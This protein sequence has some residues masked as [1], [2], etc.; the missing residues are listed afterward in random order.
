M[1]KP[2]FVSEAADW[3]NYLGWRQIFGYIFTAAGIALTIYAVKVDPKNQLLI[4][5]F[6]AFAQVMAAS[7]FSRQGKADPTHAKRSVQR[8][9]GLGLRV[10]MVEASVQDSFENSYT[11]TQR[12]EHMGQV[13]VHLGGIGEDVR[14]SV[15]DWIAFNE[16]L[17][18]LLADDERVDAARHAATLR[19]A[20]NDA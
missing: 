15:F 16:H 2:R 17:T 6:A 8:L 11:P 7:I 12:R 14:N 20:E 18:E 4:A 3:W 1:R 5:V 9:I 19:S 13:S 10:Q